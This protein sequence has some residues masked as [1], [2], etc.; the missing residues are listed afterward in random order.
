MGCIGKIFLS[1][2]KNLKIFFNCINATSNIITLDVD[3]FLK[4]NFYLVSSETCIDR[5]INF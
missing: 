3:F 2:I 1:C 5:F 4:I